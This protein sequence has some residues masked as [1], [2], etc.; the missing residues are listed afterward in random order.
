M[1]GFDSI[2]QPYKTKQLNV[3]GN[4]LEKNFLRKKKRKER[5]NS[6]SDLKF[7]HNTQVVKYLLLQHFECGLSYVIT[8]VV[9]LCLWAINFLTKNA[10]FSSASLPLFFF[11]VEEH[12]K[13]AHNRTT[14]PVIVGSFCCMLHVYVYIQY[15]AFWLSNRLCFHFILAFVVCDVR[16]APCASARSALGKSQCFGK[17][18]IN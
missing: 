1:C 6:Y 15:L 17:P 13:N 4:I 11:W 12:K 9:G 18:T 8:S 14:F 2:K 16:C 3:N 10:I 5:P 7:S